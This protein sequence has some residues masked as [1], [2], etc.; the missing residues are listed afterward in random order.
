MNTKV[1]NSVIIIQN[2]TG[3]Y[4]SVR[5]DNARGRSGGVRFWGE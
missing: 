5:L 4:S 3:Q 2:T 1:Y